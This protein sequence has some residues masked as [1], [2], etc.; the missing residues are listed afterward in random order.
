MSDST[1]QLSKLLPILDSVFRAKQTQLA[2]INHRINGLKGQLNALDRR[3]DSDIGSPAVRV[4]ADVLWDRW[5]QD[6]RK[7]IMQEMALAARDREN[8]RVVV[9]QALAKREA[10]RKL[11]RQLSDQDKKVQERR[12]SW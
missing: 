4:G 12:A 6:R 3:T 5:V 11:Q 7:L 2:Q 10:A 9:A 8:T 1:T